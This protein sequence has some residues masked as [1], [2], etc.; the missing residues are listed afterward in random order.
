MI[1]NFLD[2]ETK[3]LEEELNE[4]KKTLV[5]LQIKRQ[6]NRKFVQVLKETIEHKCA[7]FTPYEITKEE[8]RKIEELKKENVMLDEQITELENSIFEQESMLSEYKKIVGMA[9]DLEEKSK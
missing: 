9:K 8:E 4:D 3:R 6:E 1:Y 5:E 2:K 7:G